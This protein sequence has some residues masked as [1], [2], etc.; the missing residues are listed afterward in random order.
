[1]TE[2]SFPWNGSTLGDHGPYSDDL[3][4]GAW[5]RFFTIDPSSEGVLIGSGD[6][7][8]ATNPAGRTVRIAAGTALVDGS[9]YEADASVDKTLA[10]PSPGNNRYD[11]VVLRKS[12]PD[13]TVRVTIISGVEAGSP[14]VPALTQIRGDTWDVPLVKAYVTA[15]GA[16]TLT[17][18]RSFCRHATALVLRRQGGDASAWNTPGPNS[19]SPQKT[20]FQ[21]GASSISLTAA[22]SGQ[23]VVSFGSAFSAAPVVLAA[24]ANSNYI[25]SIAAVTATTVTIEI[26]HRDNTSATVTVNLTWL[27]AGPV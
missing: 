1:M 7:L 10:L 22:A 15:A 20:A 8:S 21:A 4:A 12:C 25:A 14:T 24:S 2:S 5:R 16:V 3:W 11:R 17:D 23:V 13:Q 27:A 26:R 9:W 19:Y 6:P 18:E